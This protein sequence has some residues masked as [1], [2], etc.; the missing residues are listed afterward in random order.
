MKIAYLIT[1]YAN[2]EHLKRLVEALDD[3]VCPHF[4]IHIDLKSKLP[5]DLKSFKNVK[6]IKRHK[7]WWGGWS[8]QKAIN[9]LM[10]AAYAS[11]YDHY[12]LLSGSDYPV[13]PNSFLYDKLK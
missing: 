2:Y 13:R 12:I 7:V 6:F 4:Y 1:A 5:H 11:G 3:E 8:H 10:R 9:A